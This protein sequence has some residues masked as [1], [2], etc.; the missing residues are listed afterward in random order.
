MDNNQWNNQQQ[1]YNQQTPYGQPVYNQQQTYNPYPYAVPVK[2]KKKTI[3]TVCVT[4]T[5]LLALLIIGIVTRKQ[6]GYSEQR[7]EN[8]MQ[9]KQC[10]E[11]TLTGFGI[12]KDYWVCDGCYHACK[13]RAEELGGTLEPK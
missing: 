3:I 11:Y 9:V 13:E 10:K 5:I 12:S 2:S 7:C 4:V 1:T 6:A 8:C